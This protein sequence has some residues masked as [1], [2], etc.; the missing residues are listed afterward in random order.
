MCHCWLLGNRK[1]DDNDTKASNTTSNFL[2]W[3]WTATATWRAPGAEVATSSRSTNQYLYRIL[4]FWNCVS[5]AAACRRKY[6]SRRS[7]M[8]RRCCLCESC[9]AAASSQTRCCGSTAGCWR[10]GFSLHLPVFTHEGEDI[11]DDEITAA[12]KNKLRRQRNWRWWWQNL[13]AKNKWRKQDR[14]ISR[15][16]GDCCESGYSWR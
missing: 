7:T 12:R 6:W 2:N 9:C 15:E 8:Q 5:S 10:R 11:G 1:Y 4:L 3:P 14:K 16:I 13:S